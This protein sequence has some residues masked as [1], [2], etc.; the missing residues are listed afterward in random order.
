MPTSH[1][2]P[3]VRRRYWALP[4]PKPGLLMMTCAYGKGGEGGGSVD[5]L[6]LVD[7]ELAGTHVYEQEE[8]AAGE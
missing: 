7:A 6:L 2:A 1:S 3:F 5:F 8:T 4:D